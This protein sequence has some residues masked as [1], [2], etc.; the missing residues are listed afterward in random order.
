MSSTNKESQQFLTVTI[1]CTS[2]LFFVSTLTNNLGIAK[3]SA[4]YI[5]DITRGSDLIN[6]HHLL[7]HI[8]AYGWLQLW[9]FFSFTGDSLTVLQIFSSIFGAG[10]ITTLYRLFTDRLQW[11]RFTTAISLLPILL[12]YGFW[13][14]S[15]ALEVYLVP[16]FFIVLT[17][18]IIT[19]PR[20]TSGRILFA[21]TTFSLAVLTHQVNI[22]WGIVF[23]GVLYY[24]RNSL[25]TDIKNA[26]ILFI[27][28]AN[29]AITLPYLYVMFCVKKFA[30]VPEAWNWL[31]LYAHN[32]NYW[33]QISPFTL[34][35][36]LYGFTQSFIGGQFIYRLPVSPSTLNAL[37]Q[38]FF[39]DEDLFLTRSINSNIA[40][41]L[42]ILALMVGGWVVLGLSRLIQNRRTLSANEKI[43]VQAVLLWLCV[44]TT[45]FSFWDS[46]NVEFWIPQSICIWILAFIGHRAKTVS[47]RFGYILP[48]I[49]VSLS[50][51]ISNEFGSMRWIRNRKYDYFYSR[52]TPIAAMA[53]PGDFI[54]TA[55]DWVMA[56]GIR[57]RTS[58]EVL[59]YGELKRNIPNDLTATEYLKNKIDRTLIVGKHR[60]LVTQDALDAT[61]LT[62]KSIG[63]QF[64]LYSMV[65]D[66][67]RDR[68]EVHVLNGEC[69]YVINPPTN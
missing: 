55:Y 32:S 16:L 58:A 43:I 11:R 42:S 4:I 20:I 24:R 57:H 27:T 31:T 26:I 25:D 35:K 10:V 60:V 9:R 53:T 69:I 33:N 61:P 40:I 38:R 30:S 22:L 44:Y 66:T 21:T 7:Y 50:L 68:W 34:I 39:I 46:S 52:T 28:T 62:I 18:Y 12:S 59:S 67:Y 17:L 6:P 19:H 5:N 65:V 45:F 37:R 2:L 51:G 48:V 29:A 36:I 1:Y 56:E 63:E 13:L 23:L 54:L 15:T 3:D 49:L 8:A 64:N 14:Y 47:H 41:L